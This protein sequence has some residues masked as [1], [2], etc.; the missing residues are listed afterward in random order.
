LCVT[1]PGGTV[2]VQVY[3]LITAQP[4]YRRS[5]DVAKRHA[6]PE[7]PSILGTYWKHGDADRLTARFEPPLCG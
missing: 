2:A 3:D 5:V 6:G 7:A 4:A 1:R